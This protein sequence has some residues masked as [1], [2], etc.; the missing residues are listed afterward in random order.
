MSKL[1]TASFNW[2]AEGRTR[3]QLQCTDPGAVVELFVSYKTAKDCLQVVAQIDVTFDSPAPDRPEHVQL[4]D[5]CPENN[6]DYL[7]DMQFAR[8]LG[9]PIDL[10]EIPLLFVGG[11]M[12]YHNTNHSG[13]ATGKYTV[14]SDEPLWAVE[15]G[16]RFVDV[17]FQG[18]LY[19][20][21]VIG[22][23]AIGCGVCCVC[24]GVCAY[25]ASSTPSDARGVQM[26]QL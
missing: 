15:L 2:T 22:F 10:D 13:C 8:R 11:F 6:T 26:S 7:S 14:N 20:S 12:F 18:F 9:T 19:S 25:A 1:G 5:G 16:H 3:F 21:A 4:A 24:G 23:L 17:V